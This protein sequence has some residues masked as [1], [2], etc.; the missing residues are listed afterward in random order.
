MKRRFD[1]LSARFRRGMV[2]P[3][4]TGSA[5]ASSGRA[6]PSGGAA[7]TASS[8]QMGSLTSP[9]AITPARTRAASKGPGLFGGLFDGRGAYNSL[10][11]RGDDGDL[12]EDVGLMSTPAE[13]ERAD[14]V[15]RMSGGK[16]TPSFG[17]SQG[18]NP[19]MVEIELSDSSHPHPHPSSGGGGASGGG[20]SSSTGARP[21]S[22]NANAAFAI[23]DEDDEDETA[24]LTSS[25][26][27]V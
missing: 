26:K 15:N 20:G 23:V 9:A 5:R 12:G 17:A 21:T 6:G 8:S 10:S 25:R 24:G 1:M 3:P 14:R 27:H 11:Q 22:T 16:G 7:A 13:S 18:A 4:A 2:A 19:N